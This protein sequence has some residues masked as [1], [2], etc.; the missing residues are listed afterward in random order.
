ME[1]ESLRIQQI[2]TVRDAM[3]TIHEAQANIAQSVIPAM[4]LPI[5]KQEVILILNGQ[6]AVK[7]VENILKDGNRKQNNIYPKEKKGEVF[8]EEIQGFMPIRV[9]GEII[10]VPQTSLDEAFYGKSGYTLRQLAAIDEYRNGKR[11]EASKI[12][13]EKALE[14]RDILKRYSRGDYV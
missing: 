3:L 11:E 4:D 7:G 13:N 6:D 12:K 8:P 9:D 10:S 5:R 2:T 1:R 14:Q